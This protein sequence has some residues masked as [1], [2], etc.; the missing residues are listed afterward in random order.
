MGQLGV[1]SQVWAQHL[2]QNSWHITHGEVRIVCLRVKV[3]VPRVLFRV[4]DWR[5]AGS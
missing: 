4:D 5:I 1:R 2:M 3:G